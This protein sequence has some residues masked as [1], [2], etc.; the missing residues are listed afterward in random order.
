LKKIA[1][2]GGDGQY[3]YGAIGI[4]GTSVMNRRKCYLKRGKVAQNFEKTKKYRKTTQ[5]Q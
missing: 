3:C 5:N 1:R 2:K 4:L